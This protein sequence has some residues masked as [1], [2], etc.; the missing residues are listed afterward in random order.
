L[1]LND[2][3]K[4][5]GDDVVKEIKQKAKKFS[6]KH[7]LCVNSTYQ[8]GGVAE[9]LNALVILFNDVGL[10]MGW[11]ILHGTPY[12]FNVTKKFHNALQGDKINLS[13]EKK[14]IYYETNRRFSTF[15]HINHDLVIVHDPQPLP[16]IDFYE[17]TQP[18]IWRCHIDLSAANPELWKYL[19]KFIKKYDRLVISKEDYKKNISV[20]Q[21]VIHPAI[22][23]LSEKNRP[24]PKK[25]INKYLAKYG[26]KRDLPVISQ[27]SRF[28][29]WKDPL[30]V[31]EV[32]EKVREKKRCRLV[33]LGSL[34]TDDPEGHIMFKKIEERVLA[35]ER[36][37]DIK[38]ILVDDNILVNCLQRASSVIMQKSLKEGFALTV[39][40]ALYKETPVVASDV[41]G[42]PLQVINGENGFLRDPDDHE[43]FVDDIVRLL[44]DEKLRNKMGK[45]GKEYIK[46]N[47]LITR[48]MLDWLD[49]FDEYL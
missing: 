5:V 2:Y 37:K 34:A 21:T 22:D 46:K 10:D 29:K 6:K 14:R 48:L 32:F 13:T 12:F 35:S 40:E 9:L 1:K 20:P 7:I 16:L 43:G 31:I 11:R 17:K 47:F 49:L 33:L 3:R 38:L 26:I 28:D 19:K 41:G 4:I 44:N 39:S 15:T 8:G 45:H 23:P 42:I 18:W 24:L 27:I 25:F 36:K 30:G